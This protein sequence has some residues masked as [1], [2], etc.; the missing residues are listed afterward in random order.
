MRKYDVLINIFD[1]KL[2]YYGS[3][4]DRLYQRTLAVGGRITVW[5]VSSLSR[6]DLTKKEKMLLLVFS[7]ANESK[8]VRLETSCTVILPPTVSVLWVG[9]GR[10]SGLWHFPHTYKMFIS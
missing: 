4:D 6:L 3:S 2:C 10:L 1:P 7:E 8:L 9:E 5:L